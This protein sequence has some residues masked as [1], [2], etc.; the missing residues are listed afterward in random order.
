MAEC[1]FDGDGTPAIYYA[2][3]DTEGTIVSN[4]GE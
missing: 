2:L 4:P 1:D 3:S